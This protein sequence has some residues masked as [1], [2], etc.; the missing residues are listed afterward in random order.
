MLKNGTDVHGQQLN[1]RS[2]SKKGQRLSFSPLNELIWCDPGHVVKLSRPSNTASSKE[3][4]DVCKFI[5]FYFYYFFFV[6]SQRTRSTHAMSGG[7]D[8]RWRDDLCPAFEP[9]IINCSCFLS[10]SIKHTTF[11]WDRLFFSAKNK[12]KQE[13]WSHTKT[14]A[15]KR[16]NSHRRKDRCFCLYLIEVYCQTLYKLLLKYFHSEK[17]SY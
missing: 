16:W 12:C 7:K 1:L 13:A 4:S 6:L 2:G 17:N 15:E 5:F 8:V 10:N 11:V 3:A 9:Y 14:Q